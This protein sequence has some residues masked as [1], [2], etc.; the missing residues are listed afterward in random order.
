MA[1]RCEQKHGE[2]NSIFVV[3][4]GHPHVSRLVLT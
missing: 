1:Q 4:Q 2:G 3:K